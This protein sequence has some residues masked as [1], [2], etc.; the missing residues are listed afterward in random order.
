MSFSEKFPILEANEE[1]NKDEV[2]DE[3]AASE[4]DRLNSE[5]P[6]K[7]GDEPKGSK[8]R[9]G[10]KVGLASLIGFMGAGSAAHGE[11]AEKQFSSNTKGNT[12]QLV[13]KEENSQEMSKW[14]AKVIKA[15][16]VLTDS[17]FAEITDSAGMV[18]V[19]ELADRIQ[20][21]T[22]GVYYIGK[23]DQE[24]LLRIQEEARMGRIEDDITIYAIDTYL[25]AAVTRSTDNKG[26]TKD[27]RT[28][29]GNVP[30]K[31]PLNV[32]KKIKFVFLEK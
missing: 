25:F 6:D 32:I 26:K 2:I 14:K 1:K 3:F 17:Q 5:N 22:P 30:D 13:N 31:Y 7:S 19:S 18:S 29:A 28:G 12:E 24:T 8:S 21:Y 11:S 9:T 20:R 23:K 16:T 27:V 10:L 4:E 15:D